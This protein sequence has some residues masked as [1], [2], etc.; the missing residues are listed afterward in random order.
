MQTFLKNLAIIAVGISFAAFPL[1]AKGEFSPPQK[2]LTEG[3]E[4]YTVV[5]NKQERDFLVHKPTNYREDRLLPLVIAIHGYR[6]SAKSMAKVTGFNKVANKSGFVVAYPNGGNHQWNGKAIANLN[7]ADDIDY[8]KAMV[9]LVKEKYEIDTKR[10]YVTG[11]SNGG[12]FS[13]RLVCDMPNTFA[14]VATVGS[15]MGQ[16]LFDD[17]RRT[18]SPAPMMIIHGTDDPIITAEGQ[19]ERVKR[20]FKTSNI[21]S[22]PQLLSFWMTANHCL[23]NLPISTRIDV[24]SKDKRYAEQFVYACP[25]S[26]PLIYWAIHNGGHT[27][28]GSSIKHWYD[29][30]FIGHNTN[31]I[32]ASEVIWNF[33]NT[34]R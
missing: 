13:Q 16:P 25:K 9:D 26:S 18:T 6:M 1:I 17:C 23:P 24:N 27:W 11:F 20:R 8:I 33:F 28:P 4:L 22:I 32:Q 5:I 14:A 3:M 21:I 19:I 31:D 15:T 29:P 34:R 10:I 7:T 12:F 30:L 2:S